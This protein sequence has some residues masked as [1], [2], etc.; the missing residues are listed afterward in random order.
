M[1]KRL[2][3]S[4]FVFMIYGTFAKEAGSDSL[5]VPFF[6]TKPF[7]KSVTSAEM[8]IMDT[9][10]G[11]AVVP[12]LTKNTP[13]FEEEITAFI[14]FNRYGN[15]SF[16]FGPYGNY[17][18]ELKFRKY[19]YDEID[20]ASGDIKENK[21]DFRLKRFDGDAGVGFRFGW[22]VDKKEFKGSEI[23]FTFPFTVIYDV[24]QKDDGTKRDKA[25][26]E[27][28][29]FTF[30][31]LGGAV[32]I[33]GTLKSKSAHLELEFDN[34]FLFGFEPFQPVYRDTPSIYIQNVLKVDL[35]FAPFD[36]IHKKVNV[37]LEIG[38][39][40]EV[41]KNVYHIQLK[42]RVSAGLYWKPLKYFKLILR[43][44]RYEID[45]KN[46]VGSSGYYDYSESIYGEYG[47]YFG[48]D[49]IGLELGVSPD[50]WARKD[51]VINADSVRKVKITAELTL[52]Y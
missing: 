41:T 37:F 22:K 30:L 19:N 4:L 40:L 1:K 46:A 26:P 38:D 49:W 17:N 44:F 52:K 18:G 5:K 7:I 9:N 51:N 21:S 35:N 13:S 47:A 10:D 14:R 12:G 15:S 42:N 45:F 3:F 8:G 27:A 16:V 31:Y 20:Q 28:D 32:G 50:Y 34:K 24:N 33:E 43:P 29:Y 36:F 39:K 2:L 11:D 25:I 6:E 48:S 23:Y